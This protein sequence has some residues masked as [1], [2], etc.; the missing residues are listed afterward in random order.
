MILCTGVYVPTWQCTYFLLCNR[1]LHWNM[2]CC[3]CCWKWTVLGK[4]AICYTGNSP[5]HMFIFWRWSTWALCLLPLYH[6]KCCHDACCCPVCG[7][8]GSLANP[9][10]KI[11][12][13]KM[14]NSK[15]PYIGVWISVCVCC[16]CMCGK[17]L[18]KVWVS[19]TTKCKVLWV[20]VK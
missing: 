14:L 7:K 10:V 11:F 8:G 12:L 17:V 5:L 18:H 1:T 19:V 2:C 4:Q 6:V 20:V 13:G 3:C 15:C 16:R 9:H